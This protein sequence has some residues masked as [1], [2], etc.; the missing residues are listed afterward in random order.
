[1]KERKNMFTVFDHIAL[2]SLRLL[3]TIISFSNNDKTLF[4]WKDR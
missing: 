4:L 3:C 1:M 2:F